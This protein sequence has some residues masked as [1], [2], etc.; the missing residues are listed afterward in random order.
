MKVYLFAILL[1]IALIPA[2]A[3]SNHDALLLDVYRAYPYEFAVSRAGANN[4]LK[5]LDNLYNNY[6]WDPTLK[7]RFVGNKFFSKSAKNRVLN[8]LGS[9]A[10]QDPESGSYSNSAGRQ[11]VRP[12]FPDDYKDVY[13]QI[14]YEATT[15]E[16]MVDKCNSYP[17]VCRYMVLNN[18]FPLFELSVMGEYRSF[19]VEPSEGALLNAKLLPPVYQQQ[20]E[21]VSQLTRVKDHWLQDLFVW[22]LLK[23]RGEFDDV[24]AHVIAFG[25]HQYEL[26]RRPTL[27][28]LESLVSLLAK[29]FKLLSRSES[30]TYTFQN[31]LIS[32][33][34]TM[35]GGV[36]IDDQ[37]HEEVFKLKSD[38]RHKKE[39]D[40]SFEVVKLQDSGEEVVSV[41][42]FQPWN[43]L[44]VLVSAQYLL[45]E[46]QFRA[47]V[48]RIWKFLSLQDV[49][50]CLVKNSAQR[51]PDAL[52]PNRDVRQTPDKDADLNGRL[53]F[54]RS[55]AK[56]KRLQEGVIQLLDYA[57]T[58][59]AGV[60]SLVITQR[61][62]RMLLS[63]SLYITPDRKCQDYAEQISGLI[64]L[65]IGE[66]AQDLLAEY[67]QERERIKKCVGLLPVEQ[68]YFAQIM[69]IKDV[70][71]RLRDVNFVIKLLNNKRISLDDVVTYEMRRVMHHQNAVSFDF[72]LL[73]KLLID[74]K[75]PL[76][77][78]LP[79]LKTC[80]ENRWYRLYSLLRRFSDL[81]GKSEFELS[82]YSNHHPWYMA[83]HKQKSWRRSIAVALQRLR[84]WKTFYN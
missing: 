36:L 16:L 38:V 63:F 35:A 31:T 49:N 62:V 81:D 4:D 33:A 55:L 54:A 71:E 61:V 8:L 20:V 70:T 34:L 11:L 73:H 66:Q 24:N 29:G 23:C 50:Q 72:P 76:Q 6:E 45:E 68:Q 9:A 27:E 41:G 28:Q 59:N 82:N 40:D 67:N 43:Y 2:E 69:R 19:N 74:L 83:L 51:R 18:E 22:A 13:L 39:S 47:M 84:H 32:Q 7:F 26:E 46:S 80:L 58:I 56:I 42:P 21:L 3:V 65:S 64:N 30:D 25:L 5:A 17:E 78:P 60:S 15:V 77:N 10:D 1:A 44:S 53:L 37:L 75:Y 14:W 52:K 48:A 57:Q 12:K 79:L